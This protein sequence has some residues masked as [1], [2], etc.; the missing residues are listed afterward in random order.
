MTQFW[1]N[2][3]LVVL[4][5]CWYNFLK[6]GLASTEN[7]IESRCIIHHGFGLRLYTW[8]N[9]QG[10]ATP[11][12]RGSWPVRHWKCDIWK[13]GLV[14]PATPLVLYWLLIDDFSIPPSKD[15]RLVTWMCNEVPE[16]N[17]YINDLTSWCISAVR[18]WH[19]CQ[20]PVFLLD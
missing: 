10:Q 9:G 5:W 19:P 16:Q 11:W 2:V 1:V 17:N 20:R 4:V 13:K 18:N 15:F 8:F 3:L 7:P 14:L 6:H 12:S